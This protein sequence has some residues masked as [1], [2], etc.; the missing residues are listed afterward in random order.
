MEGSWDSEVA[1]KRAIAF[2]EHGSPED[3]LADLNRL[4]HRNPGNSEAY[5]FKGLS[6]S[7]MKNYN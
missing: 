2:I 7:K 6:F 3:A 1:L 4:I 5:L